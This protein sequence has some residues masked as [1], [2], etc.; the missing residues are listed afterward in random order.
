MPVAHDDLSALQLEER[1]IAVYDRPIW[2]RLLYEDPISGEEHY[3]VR[4]DAGTTA[5]W[6][7]HTAAHTIV[8]L[9]GRLRVNGKEI[10]PLSYCHYAPGEPMRHEPAGDARVSF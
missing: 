9:S 7:R 1:T 2:L 10:G 5:R 4:Y 8:V 3:L 6:H